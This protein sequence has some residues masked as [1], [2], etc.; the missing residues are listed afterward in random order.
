MFK[1]M[2]FFHLH[3]KY[4]KKFMVTETKTGTDAAKAASK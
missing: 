3:E 4:G 1:V 2:A